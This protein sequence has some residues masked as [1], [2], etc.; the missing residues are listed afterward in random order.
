MTTN[1]EAIAALNIIWAEL[2]ALSGLACHAHLLPERT[3]RIDNAR[4]QLIGATAFLRS[5]TTPEQAAC[6]VCDKP[7]VRKYEGESSCGDP[8]CEW[9][10]QVTKDHAD[11]HQG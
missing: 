7:F 1:E 3:R 2:D 8:Q 11:D 10:I 6:A 9:R 4:S 5:R